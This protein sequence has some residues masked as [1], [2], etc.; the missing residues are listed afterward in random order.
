MRVKIST[1]EKI[2]EQNSALHFSNTKNIRDRVK[3][4]TEKKGN[5]SLGKDFVF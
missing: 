3:K 1:K 2:S 4:D 5:K